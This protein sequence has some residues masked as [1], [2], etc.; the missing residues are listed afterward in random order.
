MG[1]EPDQERASGH[2][3]GE[4]AAS[5]S[6]SGSAAD[7]RLRARWLGTVIGAGESSVLPGVGAPSGAYALI[8]RVNLLGNFLFREQYV[9]S[10]I[11]VTGV[12]PGVTTP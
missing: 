4:A 9:A 2:P 5:K 12:L 11:D 6:T 3:G 1:S 10:Q 7:V 8:C